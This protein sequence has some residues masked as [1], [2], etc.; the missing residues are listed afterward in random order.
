MVFFTQFPINMTRRESR[1]LLGSPYL[2][3]A[4]VAGSFPPDAAAT[5]KTPGRALWRVDRMGDGGS[6]LYIVSPVKPSLV[7]LDEQIG[8]PDC[9]PQWGTRDYDAFLSR[10]ENGQA[11]SFRLVANPSVSRSTRGGRTDVATPQGQSKRIGHL[12][13]LQQAAWLVGKQ[14][15]EGSGVE[16]PKL[17]AEEEGSRALRNGFEVLADEVGV[18]RLVVSNSQKVT[19]SKGAGG[20]RITLTRAQYDGVLRVVDADS[21]RRALVCGIGHGKAFGC[22][23]LTLVPLGA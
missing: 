10:I 3:H 15:Y 14:A 12:T 1:K 7:G 2:M 18:P 23:L 22:G 16:V 13:V 20:K 17:F 19:F 5:T 8:W 6:R 9:G 4:A 11:Y 21:L